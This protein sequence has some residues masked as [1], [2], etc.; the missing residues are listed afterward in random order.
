MLLISALAIGPWRQHFDDELRLRQNHWKKQEVG[1]LYSLYSVI[2]SCL[3]YRVY[4]HA[5]IC[6]TL[7]PR[8]E[9]NFFLT[10]FICPCV[11]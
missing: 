8:A 1:L 2:A 6:S 10:S 5:L 3:Q 11:R 7:K 9:D 4:R